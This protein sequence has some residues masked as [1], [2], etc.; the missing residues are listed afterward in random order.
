MNQPEGITHISSFEDDALFIK[1]IAYAGGMHVTDLDLCPSFTRGLSSD[2]VP[3]HQ[4]T[5]LRMSRRSWFLV[6]CLACCLWHCVLR[7][8]Q[9]LLGW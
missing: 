1:D 6:T 2:A 9:I 3:A 8:K 4:G 5:M 7:D